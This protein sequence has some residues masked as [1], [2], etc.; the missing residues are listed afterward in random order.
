MFQTYIIIVYVKF[1]MSLEQ[2]L[3]EY[4]GTGKKRVVLVGVGNP[5][6]GDDAIGPKIIELLET[7]PIDDILLL[8]AGSVPE[9]FTDKV[10]RFNPSHVLMIDAANFKGKPGETKLF[11]GAQIS[12]Q[13]ISSHSLPLNIFISNIEGS[14]G[15]K[16]LLLGIQPKSIV[17]GELLTEQVEVAANYVVDSL[18][19]IL[20]E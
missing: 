7:K 8:N 1:D 17:L 15:I 19:Q 18:Y 4:F 16:V 6:M 3:R 2:G 9:A 5:F 11:A 10:E 12:G 14:L 20:S 13:V